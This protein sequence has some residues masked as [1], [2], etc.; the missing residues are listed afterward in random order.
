MRERRQRPG[1]LVMVAGVG[2][3]ARLEHGL[4]QLLDEQRHAVGLGHD[5]RRDLV[6]Q[7][8]GADHPLDQGGALAPAEP[9]QRQRA[10]VRLS[11]A[12]AG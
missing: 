1:Q 8:L 3:Q 9:G 5:L 12:R 10:D 2:E 4:G 7:R 6:R 11:R